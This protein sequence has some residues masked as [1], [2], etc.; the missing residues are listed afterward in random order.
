MARWKHP[1]VTILRASLSSTIV[2]AKASPQT[3]VPRHNWRS[4][5]A[6]AFF[7]LISVQV[8]PL[9]N[10]AAA[11]ADCVALARAV[12]DSRIKHGARRVDAIAYVQQPLDALIVF[13]ST[14]QLCRSRGSVVVSAPKSVSI[15]KGQSVRQGPH[16]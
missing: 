8:G 4:L 11:L 1:K 7:L 10:H 2:D 12:L 5:C 15:P 13:P 14:A 3:W 16:R 9:L 6:G